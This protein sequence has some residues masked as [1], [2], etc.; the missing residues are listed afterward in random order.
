MGRG[1]FYQSTG[2]QWIYIVNRQQNVAVKRP[3]KLGRQN[4]AFYEV[5]EGLQA[6]EEVITSGYETFG[7]ADK[8]VLRTPR[9]PSAKPL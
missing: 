5:L 8:L 2:G 3:I 6:G 9:G 1:G 7:N 4:P